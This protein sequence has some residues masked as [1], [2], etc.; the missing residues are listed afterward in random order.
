M[1]KFLNTLLILIILPVLISCA[2]T[3]TKSLSMINL[4]VDPDESAVFFV[5]KKKYIASAGLVK[6]ILDGEEIGK[7]G[8]GE[9]ERVSIEPGSHNARVALGSILQ[10]G[11]GTDSAAFVAEKG[12]AY[13]FIV[14][15][16]AGLFSGKWTITETSKNGF[17]KARN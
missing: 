12:K 7:L 4:G 16:E 13:Y 5:R 3:G 1:R 8:V 17:T 15:F 6:I 10:A 9:M 14:D 11:T 2:G